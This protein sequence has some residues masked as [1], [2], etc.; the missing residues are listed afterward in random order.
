[1]LNHIIFIMVNYIK[2]IIVDYIS[3]SNM[4]LH[5]LLEVFNY[6]S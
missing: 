6:E 5:V 1:M 4:L 2:S 3:Y